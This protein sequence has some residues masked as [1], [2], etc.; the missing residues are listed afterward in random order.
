M[1]AGLLDQGELFQEKPSHAILFSQI[2][3]RMMM[4]NI[5]FVGNCLGSDSDLVS[6]LDLLM[7]SRINVTIDSI[8]P[9]HQIGR[10][11]KRSFESSSRTGKCVLVL[12][13]VT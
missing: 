3:H 4:K 10:F 11:I 5:R 12:S 8:Y 13:N 6:A 1:F 7:G 2:I 9:F